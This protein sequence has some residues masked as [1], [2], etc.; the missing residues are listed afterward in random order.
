MTEGL[1][2]SVGSPKQFKIDNANLFFLNEFLGDNVVTYGVEVNSGVPEM[3]LSKDSTIQGA[4]N[5]SKKSLQ[6]NSHFGVGLEGGVFQDDSKK[7]YLFEAA[8]ITIN[9]GDP[10]TEFGTSTPFELPSEIVE[11]LSNGGLLGIATQKYFGDKGM[12]IVIED[13]HKNGANY[14]LS[15]GEVTRA[16]MIQE[17]LNIAMEKL[18]KGLEAKA[19]E[20][21]LI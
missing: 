5:R 20:T 8:A 4:I 14:Y 6:N 19:R 1:K 7:M 3:P 2:V 9:T 13:I 16:S 17:A 15:N 11:A 18:D 10:Y 21:K 12:Q